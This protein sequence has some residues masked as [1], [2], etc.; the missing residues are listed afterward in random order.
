MAGSGGQA[1]SSQ[2]LIPQDPRQ[3]LDELLEV[4]ASPLCGRGE[5]GTE[6]S[7]ATGKVAVQ[8]KN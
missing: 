1:T 2:T 3:C 5:G 7:A 8:S 4:P 6:G